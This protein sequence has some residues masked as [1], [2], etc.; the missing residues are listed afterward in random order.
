MDSSVINGLKRSG[1]CA[2]G[3]FIHSSPPATDAERRTKVEILFKSS[4][5]KVKLTKS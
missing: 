4:I 2:V 5:P 1:I 3:D